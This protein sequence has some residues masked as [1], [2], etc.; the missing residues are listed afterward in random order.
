MIVFKFGE[1]LFH[2][3]LSEQNRFCPNPEFVTILIYGSHL[4]VIQIDNLPMPAHERSL[5][6]LEIFRINTGNLF[7]LLGHN[8]QGLSFTIFSASK[9]IIFPKNIVIFVS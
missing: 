3:S 9:L 4:T 5:L 6:L 1:N 2:D 8:K 7:L